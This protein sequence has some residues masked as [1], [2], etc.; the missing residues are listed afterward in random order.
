MYATCTV[1]NLG[2]YFTNIIVLACDDLEWLFSVVDEDLEALQV[3]FGSCQVGRSV[4]ILV[5]TVG[6]DLIL[7][8]ELRQEGKS[9]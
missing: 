6:I 4:S 5:L 1:C 3:S 9:N 8:N 2:Y 7:D